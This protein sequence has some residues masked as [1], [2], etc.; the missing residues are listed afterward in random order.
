MRVRFPPPLRP[1]D[2][3]GVT[4][5]SS[6]V[7]D[8]LRDRLD[9]CVQ[10]LR[11]RGYDVRL[12]QCLGGGVVSAP[13]ADRAAELTAMLLDPAVTAVVPPWG[14][15]LA[16][17]VLPL[18]DLDALA[19]A[20]P[21]W[22]VGY[23]DTTTLMLPL[24]LRTGLASVHAAGL[25]ETPYAAPPPLLHWLDVVTAEPGAVLRQAASARYQGS[26][27]DL[28]ERPHGRTWLLSEDTAWRRLGSDDPVHAT[29]RLVGGCLETVA[30]LAGTPYGDVP[31]FA[32]GEQHVVH[33]EVAEVGALDA[34]RLLHAV[35]LSGWFDRASVVLLGRTSAPS[36]GSFTQLDAVRSALGDLPVP[37][38]LDVDLGHVPPQLSLVDG[39]LATV[40]WEPG[41]GTVEQRLR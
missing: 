6:G 24:L 12:G 34:C 25:M 19:A 41:G 32:P 27:P 1:G 18:L 30:L 33:L 20:P 10:D 26:W 28:Q 38:L 9:F 16:V 35:R 22:L 39:A 3:I 15:E 23:S 7:E 11:D 17:E 31:G 2:T 37:V 21:T 13:A 4:G 29:G 36:S 14:G 40:T 5:P 8:D